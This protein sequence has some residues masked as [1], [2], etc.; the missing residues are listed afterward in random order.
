MDTEQELIR[1]DFTDNHLDGFDFAYRYPGLS[2][3]LQAAG[4]VI[5]SESDRGV[6]VL[7]D[8]RFQQ[9]RYR[10]LLPQHWRAQPCRDTEELST[11]LR[12]FWSQ[13][14]SL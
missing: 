10:Q 12:R 7:V 11:G 9:A 2:R 13:P 8:R 6:V 5:R 1:Q 14:C 3:V 4:R